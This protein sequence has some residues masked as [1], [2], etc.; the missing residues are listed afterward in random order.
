MLAFLASCRDEEQTVTPKTA[1]IYLSA[2]RKFLEDNGIDV[3]FFERSQYIRNTKCGMVN[4]YRAEIN[5]D[6]AD[7]A[8][9]ALTIDMIMR[10]DKNLREIKGYGIAQMAVHTAMLLGYTTLSR[11]SEYLLTPGDAEH[12]LVSEHIQDP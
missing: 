5:K 1:F 8:R 10:Q 12:L 4:A 6:E 11:V 9:L 2:I 7:P 3:K